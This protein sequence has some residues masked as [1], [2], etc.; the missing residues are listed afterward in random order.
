MPP[1]AL[2]L[3]ALGAL[4]QNVDSYLSLGFHPIADGAA[5]EGSRLIFAALPALQAHP[6]DLQA[7]SSLIWG[8]IL[9][10]IAT[11]KGPGVTQA[12]AHRL[13]R[14]Y[15]VP[16]VIARVLLVAAGLHTQDPPT[17]DRIG[18]LERHV[19]VGPL[20]DALRAAVASKTRLRDWHVPESEM[21]LIAAASTNERVN[22]YHLEPGQVA[23]LLRAAW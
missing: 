22:S 11:G 8:A 17:R 14:S 6:W 7:L 3:A 13:H 2:R 4:A 18:I 12:I 19:A 16:Y 23:A 5:L 20:A 1:D 15:A 21:D 10:A 9:S